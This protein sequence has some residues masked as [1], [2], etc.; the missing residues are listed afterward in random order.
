MLIEVAEVDPSRFNTFEEL[1]SS[2][3]YK[4]TF[5]NNINYCT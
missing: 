3:V 1:Q 2:E 5:S 4:R